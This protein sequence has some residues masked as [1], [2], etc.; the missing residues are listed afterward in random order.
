MNLKVTLCLKYSL[1]NI[2]VCTKHSVLWPGQCWSLNKFLPS[3]TLGHN[4]IW[5]KVIGKILGHLQLNQE[6]RLKD[7]SAEVP[8]LPHS[9]SCL[10][11]F[12]NL[13]FLISHYSFFFSSFS[14]LNHNFLSFFLWKFRGNRRNPTN[15]Y[16][17][18]HNAEMNS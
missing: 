16:C 5:N 18:K 7:S 6:C 14:F 17:G 11:P 8:A 1:S 2:S 12:L 10:F 13:F 4:R 9:P 15:G 3:R